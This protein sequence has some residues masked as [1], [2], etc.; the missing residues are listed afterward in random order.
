MVIPYDF[1]GEFFE[2]QGPIDQRIPAVALHQWHTPRTP[3]NKGVRILQDTPTTRAVPKCQSRA[4]IVAYGKF[5]LKFIKW[6][7]S[8]LQ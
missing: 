8:I 5:K 1:E 2:F 3:K 7:I 4:K 6:A